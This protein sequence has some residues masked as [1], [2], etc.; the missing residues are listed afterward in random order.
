MNRQR[1]H[2]LERR[3]RSTEP[4]DLCS[5]QE[6][7]VFYHDDMDA[8]A[9]PQWCSRCGRPISV[10]LQWPDDPLIRTGRL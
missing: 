8:P 2:S 9:G 6:A 7:D 5:D 10:A 1:I 3:L 4:C